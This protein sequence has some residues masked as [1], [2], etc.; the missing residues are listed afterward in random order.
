MTRND[1]IRTPAGPPPPPAGVH[2]RYVCEAGHESPA[3]ANKP[4][5][6]HCPY[7]IAPRMQCGRRARLIVR[8]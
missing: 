5:I 2:P 7:A 4:V 1:H 8:P 6:V 3:I